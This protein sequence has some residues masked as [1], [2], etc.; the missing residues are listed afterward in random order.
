MKGKNLRTSVE[1]V[2]KA[3]CCNLLFLVGGFGPLPCGLCQ[4]KSVLDKLK[5]APKCTRPA[6]LVKYIYKL[7]QG[8]L[9]LAWA[10]GRV[11]VSYTVESFQIRAEKMF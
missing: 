11:V 5:W 3:N 4:P 10:S 6:G 2:L 1:H 7:A 9:K 8:C